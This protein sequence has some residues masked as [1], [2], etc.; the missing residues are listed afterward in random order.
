LAPG[1]LGRSGNL[2]ADVGEAGRGVSHGAR[3]R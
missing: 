3:Y 1:R 2:V